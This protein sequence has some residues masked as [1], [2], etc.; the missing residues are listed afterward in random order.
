MHSLSLIR[1]VNKHGSLYCVLKIMQIII[2]LPSK[3]VKMKK[4]TN[5]QTKQKQNEN[6]M[7]FVSCIWV[8]VCCSLVKYRTR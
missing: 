7:V 4:K 6:K 8:S 1:N 2:H 5:K 3:R